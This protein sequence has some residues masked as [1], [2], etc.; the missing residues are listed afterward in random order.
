MFEISS[1]LAAASNSFSRSRRSRSYLDN[2][3]VLSV[4]DNGGGVPDE[5]LGKLFEAGTT[6]RAAEGGQGL[7][8]Y[9]SRALARENGGTLVHLPGEF[10]ALFELR[11]PRQAPKP[12]PRHSQARYLPFNAKTTTGVY[13]P[14]G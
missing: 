9:G 5:V 4:H 1:A 11:L 7:G 13:H 12:V 6:S 8:L 10:G 3:V 14:V 2:W